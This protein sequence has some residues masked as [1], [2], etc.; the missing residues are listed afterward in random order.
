MSKENWIRID[1]NLFENPKEVK[2]LARDYIELQAKFEE[3]QAEKDNAR[4]LGNLNPNTA[5]YIQPEDKNMR[6]AFTTDK[7]GEIIVFKK[8]GKSFPLPLELR[9]GEN[10][11]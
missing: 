5:Y 4:V 2:E 11:G 3:L 7:H 8:K 6:L 1:S 9:E 10:N